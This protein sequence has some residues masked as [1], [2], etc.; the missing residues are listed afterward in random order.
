MSLRR[1]SLAAAAAS[2]ALVAAA[3]SGSTSAPAQPASAAPAATAVASAGGAPRE[4]PAGGSTPATIVDFGFQPSPLT[5]RAGT[6]VTWTNTGSAPHTATA[7]D[8]SFDS[9]TLSSGSTFS[10]PFTKAGTYAY[11]CKIH[12]SMTGTVIVQP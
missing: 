12:S 11:H 3:C 1:L 4:V 10:Q 6:T 2:L 8:G 7:D 9:G 5:I